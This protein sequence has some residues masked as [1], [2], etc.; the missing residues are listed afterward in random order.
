MR[1]N[2]NQTFTKELK[3]LVMDTAATIKLDQDTGN[4]GEDI[5]MSAVSYL[6]DTKNTEY[7]WQ[8]Q[9]E[10]GNKVVKTGAGTNFKHKFET[11]GTYIVSLTAKNPN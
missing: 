2:D 3:L 4:I 11:V 10:D 6:S 7:T 9:D 5:S 1:T 8:I